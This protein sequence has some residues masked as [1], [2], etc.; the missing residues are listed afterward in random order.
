V[1]NRQP[2]PTR[3][4]ISLVVAAAENGVIGCDGKMPWH[5]PSDLRFFRGLTMSKPVIMGRKTYDAIGRPLDGR[6]NIVVTRNAAFKAA[7]VACVGS[8]AA[9]LD[10]ANV[11][12][13]SRGVDEVMVIGGAEIFEAT[14]ALA[15]RIYLTRI[16]AR[17]DGDTT[18]SD[19][20]PHFW[21]EVSRV[22]IQPD[23]CDTAT[24][25]LHIYER[26]A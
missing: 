2:G 12:A 22:P 21:R 8:I 5:V 9:A 26:A 18:F 1:R 24:A 20:D 25:T 14:L 7:G 23:P 17:P 19:P 15:D 13:A 6:D 4:T 3:L 16:H 10:L 11:R